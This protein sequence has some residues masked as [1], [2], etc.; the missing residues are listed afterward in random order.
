MAAEVFVTDLGGHVLCR[1]CT[2]SGIPFAAVASNEVDHLLKQQPSAHRVSQST[3]GRYL[4]LIAGWYQT[5]P[6]TVP[7]QRLHR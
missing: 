7:Q 4:H 6:P 3:H 2:V 1:A 5:G